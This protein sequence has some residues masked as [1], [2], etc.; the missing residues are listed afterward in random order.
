MT[1]VLGAHTR[2][3]IWMLVD[4]R[5]SYGG[6][7]PPKDGARKIMSL[8]TDDAV[9]ILGYAGLGETVGGAEPADWMSTVLRGRRLPLEMS[10][11]VL[12]DAAKKELPRHLVRFARPFVAGHTIIALAFVG[13]EPRLYRHPSVP[14]WRTLPRT[15]RA[16]RSSSLGL[17]LDYG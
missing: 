8:E 4:R 2:D 5:L 14:V 6:R 9:A 16:Y 10:L 7:R 12:A 11:G 3:T 15:G 17:W 1:L 13:N